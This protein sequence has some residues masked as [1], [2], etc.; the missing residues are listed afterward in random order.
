MTRGE[1]GA[2]ARVHAEIEQH[3]VSPIRQQLP[4]PASHSALTSIG[5]V[6]APEYLALNFRGLPAKNRQNVDS[7]RTICGRRMHTR[8]GQ[9]RGRKI[10]RRRHLIG[11]LSASKLSGPSHYER[12][13]NP[14][15][16]QRSLAMKERRVARQPL[17]SIVVGEDHQ[18]VACE[19]TPL[20]LGQDLPYT[21]IGA[22]E[23]PHIILSC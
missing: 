18:R 10:H 13:A 17:A 21:A 19:T 12:N 9:D 4:L 7:I 20:E 16:P 23:H 5:S 15:F 11:S 2:F 8:R 22:L 3:Q 14:A 1:I 6:P